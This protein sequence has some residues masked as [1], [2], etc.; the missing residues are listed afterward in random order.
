MK[1]AIVLFS[2]PK[3]GEEAAGRAFNA[4]GTAYELKQRGDEVSVIFQGAG[5][6]WASLLAHK[7]HAFNGLY[8]LVKD[9]VQGVSC[10]CADVFGAR[11]DAEAAGF[12]VI[13]DNQIPGTSGTPALGALAA[14]GYT[15]LTF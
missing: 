9:K 2:D 15:I 3:G 11:K 12:K 5:T 8:E 4:L 1:A 13:T 7:D 6:R 10:G 14:A